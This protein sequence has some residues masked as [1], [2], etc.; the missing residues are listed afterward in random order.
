MSVAISTAL[1]LLLAYS[2]ERTSWL[3]GLF[4]TWT[5][6]AQ[7]AALVVELSAVALLVG[8]GA[9]LILDR[10]AQAWANR[11]LVAVLSVS[12][13]ANVTAGYLR[14]GQQTLALLSSGRDGDVA[15]W[16]AYAVAAALWLVTNLAVPGLILFLSKLLER[17]I[18][19]LVSGSYDPLRLELALLRGQLAGNAELLV[20]A[21]T[22][23]VENERVC[24][25]A[26]DEVADL[27]GKLA[28]A[29]AALVASRQKL[30]D[31]EQRLAGSV[32]G[33]AAIVAYTQAQLRGA[34]ALEAIARELDIPPATLRG[35][36]QRAAVGSNG[37]A[38]EET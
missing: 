7:A 25:A 37:H 5:P 8:G 31:N 19:A 27:R 32:P 13:L 12:A 30:V 38:I 10:A 18:S 4:E 28:A 20:D 22:R 26:R 9:L 2:F 29:D 33:R 11:A 24:V 23:L 36:L 6:A 3:F 16:A 17:L 15:R 34:R 21:D 1:L 14:G 35:W